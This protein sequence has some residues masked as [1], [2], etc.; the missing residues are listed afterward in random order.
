L[1][2]TLRN[3]ELSST[4]V[5]SD[6]LITSPKPNSNSTSTFVPTSGTKL[7]TED[8]VTTVA[9]S[10]SSPSSSELTPYTSTPTHPTSEVTETQTEESA[11]T[12]AVKPKPR[13]KRTKKS[14]PSAS[15]ATFDPP[16][17]SCK[18]SAGGDTISSPKVIEIFEKDCLP[19]H[20]LN[21][22]DSLH[23]F[24]RPLAHTTSSA[25]YLGQYFLDPYNSS[26][27]V[28]EISYLKTTGTV[29]ITPSQILR[30]SSSSSL[31]RILKRPATLDF[32]LF[33]DDL[34]DFRPSE[35]FGVEVFDR[36]MVSNY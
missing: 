2:F 17:T 21:I 13:R 10:L 18:A 25:L 5:K 26:S 30:P 35:M 4:V 15:E 28:R 16:I 7:K 24:N 22:D 1:F 6:I 32:S 34:F 27:I 23:D 12:A 33:D 19:H 29:L 31:N 20:F 8:A 3:L 9:P 11:A 36:I 14:I